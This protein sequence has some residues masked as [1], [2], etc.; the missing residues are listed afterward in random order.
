MW[1]RRHEGLLSVELSNGEGGQAADGCGPACPQRSTDLCFWDR[2][3][4]PDLSK[5]LCSL[6][7]RDTEDTVQSSLLV[8][9]AGQPSVPLLADLQA[10]LSPCSLT[11][12]LSRPL[13]GSPAG[14]PVPSLTHLQALLCLLPQA[15][16]P[17]GLCVSASLCPRPR[18]FF[19]FFSL[20]LIS[21]GESKCVNSPSP[22]GRPS[23]SSFL[24]GPAL[25]LLSRCSPYS[26]VASSSSH[27]ALSYMSPL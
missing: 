23:F 4:D 7:P 18:F 21:G 3:S 8:S 12:R 19:C 24:Q 5:S 10:L 16:L 9:R 11:C 20:L 1:T 25:V 2:I 13:A 22:P 6:R 26:F 14:S 27:V 17:P 15:S